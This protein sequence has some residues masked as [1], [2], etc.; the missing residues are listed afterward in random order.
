MKAK[1]RTNLDKP[2]AERPPVCTAPPPSG[3]TGQ[4]CGR[5]AILLVHASTGQQLLCEHH[6]A[7]FAYFYS[8]EFM[9]PDHEFLNLK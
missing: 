2:R 4:T 5:D 6:A 1:R 8:G 9:P 3:A 7:A